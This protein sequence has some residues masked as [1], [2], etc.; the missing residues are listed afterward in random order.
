MTETWNRMSPSEICA[1]QGKVGEEDEWK[2]P[3]VGRGS[4]F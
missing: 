4:R 1:N 3:L 2:E